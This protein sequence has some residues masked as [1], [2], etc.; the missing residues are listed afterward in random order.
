M[1]A[2]PAPPPDE[3]PASSTRPL[4]LETLTG[5]R[6]SRRTFYVEYRTTTE[7]L[8]RSVRSL[9]RVSHV[10]GSSDEDAH[11][12]ADAVVSALADHLGARRVVLWVDPRWVP[13]ATVHA[14]HWRAGGAVALDA[15]GISDS[16][17][18]RLRCT[19]QQLRTR[20]PA[21]DPFSQGRLAI[22]PLAVDGRPVGVLGAW[23]SDDLV[24]NGADRAVLHIL[25]SQLAAALRR[26]DLL[27]RS[28]RL[29][30]AAERQAAEIAQRHRELTETRTRLTIAEQHAT[31]EV[32][33]RRIAR[34]LHDAVAQ[35][36]L[37]AGMTI[38]WCRAEAQADPQLHDRLTHAKDLT[39]TALHRLRAS[40]AA[41]TQESEDDEDLAGM[42]HRLAKVHTTDELDVQVRVE[43]RPEPLGPHHELALLRTASEAVFNAVRHGAASRII[44]RLS[45][46]GDAVRLSVA[47]D[48]EG[49]P[50]QLRRSLAAARDRNDGYQQG[51]PN[52]AGR[53]EDLGGEVRFQRAR[54]GGVRVLVDLPL[55]R[56]RA[57]AG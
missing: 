48:G 17:A 21:C 51:L 8:E 47:D 49:R 57:G 15:D 54:L 40:I 45:F 31:I 42:L 10:L 30:R 13:D 50:E 41:L 56:D 7:R 19:L 33:R 44:L 37:S 12:L 3:A 4:D 39:R 5:I 43:G 38:E 6:S 27:R 35:H 9:E 11:A 52:I 34:E 14:A 26:D 23:T 2:V 46:R 32:E 1:T 18:R 25:G 16:E 28:D 36:L 29:R 53:A 22:A 20:D 55:R 24:L